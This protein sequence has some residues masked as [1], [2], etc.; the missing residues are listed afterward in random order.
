[1]LN[2]V[3][4]YIWMD[5]KLKGISIESKNTQ[6]GVRTKELW[7]SEVGGLKVCKGYAIAW[8]P[9]QLRTRGLQI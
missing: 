5:S 4:R 9:T 6:N 2:I 1:M 7:P 3:S 8:K